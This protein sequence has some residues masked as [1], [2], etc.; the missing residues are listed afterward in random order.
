MRGV[1]VGL[2]SGTLVS[3]KVEMLHFQFI[4]EQDIDEV[5]KFCLENLPAPDTGTIPKQPDRPVPGK[6]QAHKQ[7]DG[8]LQVL[9]P[10]FQ[11]VDQTQRTLGMAQ[12]T[13]GG[14]KADRKETSI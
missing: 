8:T 2:Y 1:C 12:T 4:M 14:G 11:A 9:S 6:V 5:L 10:L 7:A 13:R 3:I